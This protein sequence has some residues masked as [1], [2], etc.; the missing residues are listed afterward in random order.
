[1]STPSHT[2]AATWYPEVPIRGEFRGRCSFFKTHKAQPVL[3][4]VHP[5]FPENLPR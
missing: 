4:W 2:L 5:R 1:M 3:G